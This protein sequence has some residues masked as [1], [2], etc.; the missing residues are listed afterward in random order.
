MV[1]VAP[2]VNP[3]AETQQ[4]DFREQSITPAAEL[5]TWERSTSDHTPRTPASLGVEPGADRVAFVTVAGTI[6]AALD[7][8]HGLTDPLRLLSDDPTRRQAT[9]TSFATAQCYLAN[10]PAAFQGFAAQVAL[11]GLNAVPMPGMV[12]LENNLFVINSS[13]AVYVVM[14]G[15][16]ASVAWCSVM[17]DR[18]TRAQP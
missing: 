7:A 4:N 3:I 16:P 8:S 10:D 12:F 6:G 2:P 11:N 14:I 17:I 18:S 15:T 1:D 13:R 5:A 9:I